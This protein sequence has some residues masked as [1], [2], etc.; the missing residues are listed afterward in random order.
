VFLLAACSEQAAKLT[1]GDSAPA[2]EL[3]TLSG[4]SLSLP[5]PGKVV[6]VRFWAD[7][8]PFCEN[9][10]QAIELVYQE[11]RDQGLVILA[12]NVRQDR[13]T[14]HAFMDKLD[15]TYRALLDED[16]T[17]AR[18]YGVT[19]L[20]TTFFID[21]NGRVAGRILGESTAEVFAQMVEKLL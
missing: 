21:R 4:R 15:V 7:W 18:D 5:Q 2:F 17:V 12:V 14:V 10:M 8:C 6:A 9:E 3:P 13:E 19:G 11:Y 1:N 16:G 20:P